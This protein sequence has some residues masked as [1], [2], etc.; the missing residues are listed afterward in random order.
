M[1][2]PTTYSSNNDNK[3]MKKM[4]KEYGSKW[5]SKINKQINIKK[6]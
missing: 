3:K 1:Y 2:I 4:A 5:A 6:I